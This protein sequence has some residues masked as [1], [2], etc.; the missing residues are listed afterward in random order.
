[1]VWVYLQWFIIKRKMF[2][3]YSS[4]Y[5]W[6]SRKAGGWIRVRFDMFCLSHLMLLKKSPN[7]IA[8]LTWVNFKFYPQFVDNW[9]ESVG[10]LCFILKW[11]KWFFFCSMYLNTWMNMSYH[12]KLFTHILLKIWCWT[13]FFIGYR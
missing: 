7:E 10:E 13:L 1:M 8:K 3:I 11:M 2:L 4:V 12:K 5:P 9:F 6:R